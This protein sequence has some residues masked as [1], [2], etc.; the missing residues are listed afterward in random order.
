MKVCIIN[1]YDKSKD[2]Q[3]HINKFFVV[4]PDLYEDIFF[5]EGRFNQPDVIHSH[6]FFKKG[7]AIVEANF[8]FFLCSQ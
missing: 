5:T 3:W 2:L 1:Q 6:G 7:H 8:K 4:S